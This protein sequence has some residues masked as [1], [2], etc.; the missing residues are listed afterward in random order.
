MHRRHFLGNA[1]LAALM[2][3]LARGSDA[4]AAAPGK[5]SLPVRLNKGD[6]VGLVSPS[7]AT[8]EPLDLQLAGEAM[9]ALGFQVKTGAH[10]AERRGYLAGSDAQR[11]GDL[12]AMFAD[13]D[14][15]AIICVRGGSGAARLLPLLD[16][17]AIRR[18][19]KVLLG[20]SDTT[21]LHSAI[22]A[23]TGLVTFTQTL[24]VLTDALSTD[25]MKRFQDDITGLTTVVPKW[26]PPGVVPLK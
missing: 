25:V 2:L 9:Q 12:N 23:R 4:L 19:P 3:P 18:N 26:L 17:D 15:K 10:Y 21:A 1:A 16:Y 5:R 14:V 24:I 6:T 20:Y 11:A 13:P 22:H 7:S 8:D